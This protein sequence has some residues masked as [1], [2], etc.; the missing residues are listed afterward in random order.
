MKYSKTANGFFDDSYPANLLPV[1]VKPIDDILYQDLLKGMEEK[2]LTSDSAGYPILVDPVVPFEILKEDKLRE[3]RTE[4][5]KALSLIKSKYS[6][7]EVLSWPKQEKE[8]IGWIAD[9]SFPTPFLDRIALYR[10]VDKADLISWVL[11]SAEYADLH[12]SKVFGLRQKFTD[13]VLKVSA[14]MGKAGLDNIIVAY[15]TISTSQAKPRLCYYF[16][17]VYLV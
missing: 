7:S 3:I 12:S 4:A 10:E 6:E 8:A 14:S 1:D 17:P 2:D 16:K 15:P 5:E 11:E 9:N 13:Q